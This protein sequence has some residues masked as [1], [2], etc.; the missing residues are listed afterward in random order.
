V[1]TWVFLKGW[2]GAGVLL[3]RAKPL[4]VLLA[5]SGW[6][7]LVALLPI[8]SMP[9][10][11]LLFG[12]SGVAAPAG[13]ILLFFVLAWMVPFLLNKGRIPRQSLPLIGFVFAALISCAGAFFLAIPPFKDS[14]IPLNELKGLL[15]LAVGVCFYL[16]TAVWVRDSRRMEVTLRWMNW[17]GLAV[18]LWSALQLA[19]WYST[20]HYPEWLRTIQSFFSVGPLYRQRPTG[21]TLEP[22]FLANQLNMLYLPA[23]LAAS[24]RR[25]S[26]HRFHLAGF[27]FEDALLAGGAV[28]MFLSLSRVGMLAFFLMLA[29]LIFKGSLW[30]TGWIQSKLEQSRVQW[31]Y[32]R[33]LI[34]NMILIALF[35]FYLAVAVGAGFGLSRLDPRMKS[36]FQFSFNVGNPFLKYAEQLTFASRV[37]YWQAGWE[38]FN[39]HPWLGV[40]LGNSGFYFPEK[41]SGFG[42]GLVEVRRLMYVD[43]PLPNIK[44]LWVRLLA[45]TGLVGFAFF[46]CWL[47]LA[48]HTSAWLEKNIA[49]QRGKML[50]LMGKLVIIALVFEGFSVDSFALPYLWFALGLVTAASMKI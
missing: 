35:L 49:G 10:V 16:V 9:L 44:S 23:W 7:L 25:I 22:S 4:L 24:I 37:V 40:G 30:L 41:M 13:V 8:T 21:F 46:V 12:S 20:N 14:S 32:R 34:S 19:I 33:K 27:I 2:Q 26:A 17:S 42:W 5:D 39:D 31:A 29:Y 18:L 38:V 43:T 28:T 11:T 6:L 1:S 3:K 48:W 47:Y 50:A 36:L 15:T 45:E